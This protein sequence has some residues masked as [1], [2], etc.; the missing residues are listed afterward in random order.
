M[1]ELCREIILHFCPGA[2]LQ[3][4]DKRSG[5][6]L[7][8]CWTDSYE[9]EEQQSSLGPVASRLHTTYAVEPQRYLRDEFIWIRSALRLSQ[10]TD[11]FS[12]LPDRRAYL[13]AE[14]VQR[15]GRS[16][17]LAEELRARIL[18][19]LAFYEDHL[20]VGGFADPAALSLRAHA[21]VAELATK[22][23]P[24]GYRCVLVDEMQDFGVVELEVVRAIVHTATNALLLTGDISQQVYPKRH[25]LSDAGIKIEP[26]HR[27]YIK[28]NYRNTRQVLSAGV[29][30]LKAHGNLQDSAED[31]VTVLDPEMSDRDSAVPLAVSCKHEAEEFHFISR[32]SAQ[33]LDQFPENP[34]CI[35]VCGVREDDE[36]RLKNVATRFFDAKRPVRLLALDRN[37]KAG[38]VYLAALETLKGFEFPLVFL[39]QCS[40]SMIP[41]SGSPKSEQWRDA[42]RVYVAMTRARDEVLFT[43]TATPSPF[44]TSLGSC[45]AWSTAREQGLGYD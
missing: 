43:Y 45:V 40:A 35:A 14:L 33:H 30:L 9:K 15:T 21:F 8:D 29:A 3:S 20:E 10:S 44:L 38:N 42:R 36:D 27:R 6:T 32:Y 23:H 5:E 13:N 7:E 11:G 28:K 17:P 39:M 4:V 25:S 22:P 19:G 34:I 41:D 31:G 24:F 12:E 2:H 16:I 1:D 18:T 26:R 37:V